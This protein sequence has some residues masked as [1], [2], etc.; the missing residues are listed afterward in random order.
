MTATGV[1]DKVEHTGRNYPEG[2]PDTRKGP[3]GHNPL[4]DL[5]G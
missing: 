4:D 3:K 1:V 2:L 5:L